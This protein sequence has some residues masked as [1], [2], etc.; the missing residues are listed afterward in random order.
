MVLDIENIIIRVIFLYIDKKMKIIRYIVLLLV[1]I[2]LSTC[3]FSR[4]DLFNIAA[5]QPEIKVFPV[6]GGFFSFGS[7]NVYTT[8]VQQFIITNT[9]SQTLELQRIYTL[10]PELLQY[11]ID[12]TETAST[13][14][15]G[16][17][18]VFTVSFKP[19][20]TFPVSV[21][22]VIE[23]N[24]PDNNVFT[25]LLEGSGTGSASPP[26]INVKFWDIDIPIGFDYPF[27]IIQ[28]GTSSAAEFTIENSAS[29]GSAD[30][31]I[32][33]VSF[34]SGDFSQ[35]GMVAPGI[36]TSLAPGEKVSF[37]VGFSPLD[38]LPHTVEVLV[39]SDD[40]DEA[41]YTFRASGAGSQ[42]PVPDIALKSGTKE[43]L[44]GFGILDF[45]EV[46]VLNTVSTQLTV[47]NKGTEVLTVTGITITPIPPA[48]S[49]FTESSSTI[50]FSLAPG[51]TETII[52]DFA[53]V[54]VG[55]LKAIIDLPQTLPPN[56]DPDEN[57]FTFT[58]MGN[59]TPVPVPDIKLT[60]NSTGVEIP[61]ATL[62]H[63]FGKIN[64]GNSAS[65]TFEIE[66]VGTAS[67]NIS[68]I[69]PSGTVADFIL[70]QSSMNTTVGPGGTTTF[71][72][73][74]SPVD[75]KLKNISIAIS[76]DDPDLT[77]N[78][79]TFNVK[80]EGVQPNQPIMKIFSGSIEIPSGATFMFNGGTPV[81][82]GDSST[83]VLTI[84]NTG[85]GDLTI[86]PGLLLKPGATN[87]SHD[88][89]IPTAPATIAPG[90]TLDFTVTF[91]PTSAKPKQKNADLQ[92]DSNDPNK[93]P[94]IV[95]LSGIAQ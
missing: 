51:D 4:T 1:S 49:E 89:T 76:T 72:V 16:D 25:I 93:R 32:S 2:T 43:F 71:D 82:V 31:L 10:N 21:D 94:Y 54:S 50:P 13:V 57:P 34:V 8:R 64:V 88:L 69:E 24:D 26:D 58:V 36:P 77:E 90:G 61:S 3:S 59:A 42:T 22:L 47:E 68:K 20:D 14:E 80:G 11:S 78:P 45:G 44:N 12:A 84:K 29:P 65:V 41:L 53:P 5:G 40:P 67:L 6:E 86:E 85:D 19:T 18:T 15:P 46:E 56:N 30:L 52:I 9:G 33:D 48:T 95:K 73:I 87:F 62:G 55:T 23:S 63:D 35:F 60:N 83:A 27:G 75:A 37:I 74:F 7:V 28:A 91:K 17:S 38:A 92:I 70:D 66:N 81:N 79:Y 39:T